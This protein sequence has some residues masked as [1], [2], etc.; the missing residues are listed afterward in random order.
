VFELYPY[1]GELYYK[2]LQGEHVDPA[3][4]KEDLLR[5]KKNLILG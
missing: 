2:E 1:L 5:K 3:E 4:F